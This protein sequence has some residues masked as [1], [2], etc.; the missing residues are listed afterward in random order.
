MTVANRI[1]VYKEDNPEDPEEE[2]ETNDY[3]F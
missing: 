3:D 1:R 2:D